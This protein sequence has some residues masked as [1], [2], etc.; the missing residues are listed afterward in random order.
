[1]K[2]NYI[3]GELFSGERNIKPDVLTKLHLLVTNTELPTPY[4]PKTQNRWVVTF[5]TEF[6]INSYM[7]SS[8]QRPN[9][10]I[11][12]DGNISYDVM[13]IVLRDPIGPSTTQAIWDVL[14][15]ITDMT[16][17]AG[18]NRE[19]IEKSVKTSLSKFKDGFEY[20]LELLDPIG[21]TIEKWLING[22]IIN[23]NFGPLDYE[24]N[25]TVKC[26]MTVKPNKIQLLY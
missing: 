13:T 3:Q 4:E 26:T 11:S 18:T 1:M 25:K 14:I 24:S 15:G 12:H 21:I 19:E 17:E 22:K 23:V 7:L 20:V 5:P 8:T 6:G 10:T 16:F 9:I 2:P